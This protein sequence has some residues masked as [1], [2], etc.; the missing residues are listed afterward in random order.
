VQPL[1]RMLDGIVDRGDSAT[2]ALALLLAHR[3]MF[4]S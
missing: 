4:R 3:L 2:A 1:E